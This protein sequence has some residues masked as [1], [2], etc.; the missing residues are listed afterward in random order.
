MTLAAVLIS[1]NQEMYIENALDGILGQSVQPDEVIIADDCS[2][3][4]TQSIILDYINKHNLKD[5]WKIL[6]N[7]KNLGI[8]GNL[9]NAINHTKADIII[10]MTGDDISLDNRCQHTIEIFQKYPDLSIITT[11]FNKIDSRG[12]PIG[13]FC[14]KDELRNNLIDTIKNGMPNISPIGQA[15]KRDIFERFGGLPMSVP[16]ED[17]QIT[18]W[19]LLTGGIFCSRQITVKYRIH[20]GSACSWLRKDLSNNAYFLRFLSDMPIR[21]KHMELWK[22]SVLKVNIKDQENLLYLLELKAN[23]YCYMRHI[24]NETFCSR[25]C[26]MKKHLTVMCFRERYYLLGGKFGVLSWRWMRNLLKG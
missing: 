6:F 15:W 5:K 13:E 4:K 3:D 20:S 25:Y 11:S 7:S 19:G 18:F 23:V 21:Q 14:Y 10:P 22:D 17:D 26:F 24:T 2:T 9:Q 12:N 8:N 16:N 1:Y